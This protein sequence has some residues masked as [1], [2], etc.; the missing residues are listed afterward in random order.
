MLA[1]PEP[2]SVLLKGALEFSGGCYA[3]SNSTDS[4]ALCALI[5]AWSGVGVHFQIISACPKET[6][7][8]KFYTVVSVRALL[9]FA[10]SFVIS[11][12]LDI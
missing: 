4:F 10:L 8:K 9:S 6:S 12:L 5:L 11:S 3:A 7:Y 1:L 2:V